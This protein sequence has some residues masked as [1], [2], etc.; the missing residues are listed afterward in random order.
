MEILLGEKNPTLVRFEPVREMSE[1]KAEISGPIRLEA[2]QMIN[3]LQGLIAEDLA[4]KIINGQVAPGTTLPH[5]AD[6][7]AAYKVSRTA[8]REGLKLI[9]A[10]GLI[11]TR[12][13]TGTVVNE[14][15]FWN[16]FDPLVLEWQLA[17]G[18]VA[19]FLEKL[20]ILRFSIEPVAC[21]LAAQNASLEDLNALHTALTNMREGFDDL[22]AWVRADLQFHEAIYIASGNE[23]FW[24]FGRLLA[25]AFNA[26]F[27]ISS[28]DAH[29]EMCWQA[30]KAIY[31]AIIS[32][33]PIAATEA[34]KAVLTIGKE[35]VMA[36]N[37]V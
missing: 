32:R 9:S 36:H 26:S 18:D 8:L 12:S 37:A 34:C 21:S 11:T 3:G 24:P 2:S 1:I 20:S 7:C 10:K 35:N 23:L 25:P 15:K 27:R 17:S 14:R 16:F 29:D 5:E 22:G 31:D 13:R 19:S 6:L 30:H 28:F 4:I 33:N